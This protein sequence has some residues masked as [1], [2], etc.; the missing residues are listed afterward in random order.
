MLQEGCG[1]TLC[2]RPFTVEVVVHSSLPHEHQPQPATWFPVPVSSCELPSV[3][4]TC[5]HPIPTASSL[6]SHRC[7]RHTPALYSPA[8]LAGHIYPDGHVCT[9]GRAGWGWHG[10]GTTQ[11]L[12]LGFLRIKDE[13]RKGLCRIQRVLLDYHL[14]KAK[15][16]KYVK[17]RAVPAYGDGIWFQAV[18][19]TYVVGEGRASPH[20]PQQSH[21]ST[22]KD[23]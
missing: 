14:K 7:Q 4:H 17:S 1:K 3:A 15:L 20:S 23:R 5:K 12:G 2:R 18:V 11:E 6:L 10:D 19:K 13:T 16:Y 9:R 8:P 21:H 22:R